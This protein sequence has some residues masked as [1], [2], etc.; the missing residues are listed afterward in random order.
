MIYRDRS[1]NLIVEMGRRITAR[2]VRELMASLG[3]E[4]TVPRQF[5]MMQMFNHGTHHRSQVTAAL[6]RMGIAYGN[7][8]LP[9]NP[10]SQY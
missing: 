1:G 3:R 9:Y 6:H 10:L 4:R 8:D 5:Y 7:T 2:H